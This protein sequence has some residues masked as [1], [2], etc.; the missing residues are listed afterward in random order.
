MMNVKIKEIQE[1]IKSNNKDVLDQSMEIIDEHLR[2]E[3][4]RGKTA[5][6]R[7]NTLITL[8]GAASAVILFFGKI[9]LNI[10]TSN[11]LILIYFTYS[12]TILFLM[13]SIYYSIRSLKLT[14]VYRLSPEIIY[15]IQER[16]LNEALRYEITW[17]IWEYFQ[18]IPVNTQR[19]FWFNRGQRNLLFSIIFFLFLGL[20][21]L[22]NEKVSVSIP[23]S[24]EYILGGISILFVVFCD[25]ILDRFGF[26]HFE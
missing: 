21:L 19:L 5:G 3:V 22:I 24:I 4:E 26:W 2:K 23:N 9:I 25:C 10:C 8:S 6:T 1:K 17:K 12:V 13:K 15:D 7:V 14:Q 11:F 18:M 16:D 20:L